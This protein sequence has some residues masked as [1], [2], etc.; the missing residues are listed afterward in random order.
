MEKYDIILQAGQSNADGYGHGPAEVSYVPDERI[1]YL[2]AGNPQAGEY[3]PEG[4]LA[5]SIAAER[6]VKDCSGDLL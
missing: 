4:E 3:Y 5:I 1:L 2:T 6:P